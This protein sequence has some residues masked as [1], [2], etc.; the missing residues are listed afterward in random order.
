MDLLESK[1]K[2][3]VG[4]GEDLREG[5]VCGGEFREDYHSLEVFW[6]FEAEVPESS[7]VQHHLIKSLCWVPMFWDSS[8]DSGLELQVHDGDPWFSICLF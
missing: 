8:L 3:V 4:L 7:K 2:G 1:L 5:I 6:D